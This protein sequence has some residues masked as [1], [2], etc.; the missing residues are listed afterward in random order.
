MTEVGTTAGGPAPESEGWGGLANLP[1]AKVRELFVVLGKALRAFQLYDE[2]NPVRQRFLESLRQAFVGLWPEM[3]RLTLVVEEDRLIL[4]DQEVYRAENRS[5]SLAFL[6]YKDGVREITFLAGLE[7]D[8]LTRFLGVLQRARKLTPEGDDL[9]TVLWEEDLQ[10]FKYQYVDFLAE[11]VDLP[12][13]GKGN[14]SQDMTSV[15]EAEAVEEETEEEGPPKP[16]EAG[17]PP[18]AKTVNKDDFNPT[19]Y[20]LDPREMQVLKTELE[21]EL[22]RDL[23]HDVLS[24]LFDRLEEP[25]RPERQSEVLRDLATLL[26]NFLS[27]GV[28]AAATRVLEEL[29]KLEAMAGVFDEQRLA[30]SR[31]LL[32]EVS[33]PDAIGELIQA[34]YDGS[35]RATP[36]QL[37]A[38]LRFLRAGALYP[39]LRA[40]E[41]VEHKELQA[42]LRSSVKGIAERNRGAV[43][44]L[45][46]EQDAVVASGAARLAGDMQITE[47]GPAL[48]GLLAHAD[49]KVRLAA[50]EAAVSLKA[51]TAAGALQDTLDDPEREIRIAAA[52]ALG[53]LRYGP[54]AGRLEEILASKELRSA[55]I[56]EKVAFFEAF[57]TVA[58]ERAVDK[59]DKL[60]NSK[61]FLGKREP[62]EIRAAAALALGKIP[63]AAAQA[64]LRRA[65]QEEDAVVR[66][67]VNRALRSEE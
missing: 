61:G 49:G 38:F 29:R 30:E 14:T 20:S 52:R 23:R 43:V 12:T 25:E 53:A 57:G 18:G 9:L 51:S 41:T 45:L 47:A 11:G 63:G 6:F 64:A 15:L 54:A 65:L 21:K 8:E 7:Q 35:I 67:A 27:R 55:D 46:S 2:N 3:D 17:K 1:V 22:K 50:V 4:G 40:S 33:A 26:P 19:L 24:A 39:L 31:A 48:A 60:L 28:L 10:F 58:G 37:A 59:L 66:S 32:D 5:D 36:Q 62:S 44:R 16:G 56:S 34:L 13:A 42:V